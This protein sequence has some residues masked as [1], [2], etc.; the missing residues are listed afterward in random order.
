MTRFASSGFAGIVATFMSRW[1]RCM[2]TV[3]IAVSAGLSS[4]WRYSPP[5]SDERSTIST[6]FIGALPKTGTD[7]GFR[8][9][10]LGCGKT[11][12]V[13]DFLCSS[14]M[15]S[16]A[17][18]LERMRAAE[19]IDLHALVVDAHHRGLGRGVAVEVSE[20]ADHRG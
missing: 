20:R 3:T 12:S 4:S 2:S 17:L 6:G 16:G 8:G 13:P 10:P 19:R 5:M 11:W 18:L 7:H 9:Y 14:V 1:P 15:G